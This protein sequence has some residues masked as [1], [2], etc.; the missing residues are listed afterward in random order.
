MMDKFYGTV[1][2]DDEPQP[3]P[4]TVVSD[5][6]AR[7]GVWSP[8]TKDGKLRDPSAEGWHVTGALKDG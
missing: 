8:F 2:L 6:G 1:D 7:P 4:V 3:L 5:P